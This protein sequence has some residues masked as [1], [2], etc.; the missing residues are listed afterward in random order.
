MPLTPSRLNGSGAHVG[1]QWGDPL[2]LG[3]DDIPAESVR[4]AAIVARPQNYCPMNAEPTHEATQAANR[5]SG[6]PKR[7]YTGATLRNATPGGIGTIYTP[8]VL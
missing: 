1:A 5:P 4:M 3:L 6:A 2:T 7:F 8:V